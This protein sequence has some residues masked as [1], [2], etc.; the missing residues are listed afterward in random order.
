MVTPCG[1]CLAVIDGKAP[2]VSCSGICNKRFHSQCVDIT[3]AVMKYLNS[4][5]GLSW[6][7]SD[8]VRKCFYLDHTGL[9]KLLEDKHS[10]MLNSLNSVFDTLK[11]DFNKIADEKIR[12]LHQ[13]EMDSATVPSY[14]KI[15]KDKTQPA[16]IIKPK[17]II[18]TTTLTKSDIRDNIN[19]LESQLSFTKIKNTQSGGVL[20]GFPSKE[21]NDRFKKRATDKLGANYEIHEIKGVQPR[22]KIV[23]LSQEYPETELINFLEH[24]VKSKSFSLN[25][26]PECKL[27]KQWP[28]KK[29]SKVYQAVLQ[30]DQSTYDLI[31][32]AGGIF[33]G[34][35]YCYAYDAIDIVRCFNCNGFNHSS[36]NC[37][38]PKSCPKCGLEHSVSDCKAQTLNCINCKKATKDS[39]TQHNTN[40]AAWDNRC[41]VYQAAVD[42]FK[43]ENFLRQ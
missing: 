34:Y 35:D 43:K 42:Q 9:N 37:R 7:C 18:Q 36:R 1:T 13:S 5:P 25:Y 28:T 15:L 11:T 6:K 8:C 24:S 2:S 22:I 32:K 16:V 29:N 17:N 27:L 41:P 3:T 31:M 39:D 10:E 23:G 33:I 40:H 30:I 14:S 20:I 12:M 21:E 26:H 19:P 38:Q 4:V